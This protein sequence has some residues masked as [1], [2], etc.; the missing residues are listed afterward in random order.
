MDSMNVNA[1]RTERKLVAI[2]RAHHAA[3]KAESQ[4]RK[5]KTLPA[6]KMQDVLDK[7]VEAGLLRVT[8]R[9]KKNR[10]NS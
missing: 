4:R 10:K 3:L 9:T 5:E 2:T 8:Q 1:P 7:I 6:A